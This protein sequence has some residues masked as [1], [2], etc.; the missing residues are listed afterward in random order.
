MKKSRLCFMLQTHQKEETD[1]KIRLKYENVK[2]SE[3]IRILVEAL[4]NGDERVLSLL[5]EHRDALG[6]KKINRYIKK[7]Y[8]K[9]RNIEESYTM[10]VKEKDKIYEKFDISE[11]ET[12]IGEE[13]E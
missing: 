3:F 1:L 9:K 7:M 5:E 10:T 2:S 8:D 13:N 6:K 11:L 12:L 4:L